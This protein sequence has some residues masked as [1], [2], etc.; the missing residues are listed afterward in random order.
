MFRRFFSL[1]KARC[2]MGSAQ[3]MT[4]SVAGVLNDPPTA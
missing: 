1:S 2:A 4:G 3:R